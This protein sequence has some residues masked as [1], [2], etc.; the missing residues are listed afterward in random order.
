MEGNYPKTMELLKK[1]FSD[2]EKLMNQYKFK[3]ITSSFDNSS[4]NTI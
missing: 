2:P 4:Y 3:D 1:I